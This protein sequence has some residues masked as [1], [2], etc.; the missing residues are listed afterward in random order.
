[1]PSRVVARPSDVP[2]RVRAGRALLAALLALGAP[3]AAR[4]QATPDVPLNDIAYRYVDALMA[5]GYLRSLSALERPYTAGALLAASDTALRAAPAGRGAIRSYVIALR[6]ALQRYGEAVPGE[7]P[8]TGAP[9]AF[10]SADVF[11]TAATSGERQPMRADTGAFVA[12]GL[13]ARIAFEAGPVVAVMHPVVDNALNHDPEFGGRKDRALAGRTAEGYVAGQWRY[14][15]LFLGRIARSWG[16]TAL[17]GLTVGNAPYSYDHLYLRLG[18]DRVHLSALAAKLDDAFEPNGVYARYFYSHRLGVRWR[19]LE[20]A[21][22]ESYLAAGIGR[23]YDLS[24]LNPTNVYALVRRNEHTAG[25]L[26]LGG[27]VALRTGGAGVYAAQLFIDDL[28]ID[29][30]GAVCAEPS[31]YGLT[32]SAEGVPIPVTLPGDERLFAS[33]TRLTG[34]AY[35]SSSG[36]AEQY[37]SQ[38]VGLGRATTDYDEARVGVDVAAIPYVT[39]RVYGAYRRQGE[40]D[41]HLPFPPPSASPQPGFLIGTVERTTR[42]GASLGAML[43]PGVEVTADVGVNHVTNAWHERGAVRTRPAGEVRVQWTPRTLFF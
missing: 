40:G 20:V 23:S 26:N 4:A 30:C 22:S 33:Y 3:A 9:R 5:R 19:G 17:P 11:A 10:V 24:L 14:A 39:A 25:N 29:R 15:E 43:A 1:M 12:G 37:S 7:A 18:T 38:G 36:Y 6:T 31:S 27:D 16:P 28:Q 34:L 42:L 35:R 8:A 13:G 32:V 21:A 41:F 2:R